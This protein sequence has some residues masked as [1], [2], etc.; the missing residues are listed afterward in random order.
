V[1]QGSVI[2]GT[3]IQGYGIQRLALLLILLATFGCAHRAPL[4]PTD[5]DSRQTQ[6]ER[7]HHWHMKGKLGV[8]IPGDNGSA[9]LHWQQ[10]GDEFSLDLTGPLGSRRVSIQGHPG[11]VSLRES[12]GHVR[13]ASSAEDLIQQSLGWT[14]PVSQLSY[15]VRG[16]P[17]PR[18]RIQ[19][20]EYNDSGQ[21]SL[22][23]Q[24]GWRIHYSNYQ[25]VNHA[26]NELALP[27]KIVAEYKEVRL[28]LVIRNWQLGPVE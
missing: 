19:H 9:N 26:Q 1:I 10:Q 4:A 25:P 20:R 21:F 27:G 28:T 22:L 2:Q 7:I 6:L 23:E 8:R 12:S 14:L 3:V 13:S 16:L 24:A 18:Q 5:W 17:A 15:W 11:E